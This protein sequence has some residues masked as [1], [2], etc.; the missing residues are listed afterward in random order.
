MRFFTYTW[1]LVFL[2]CALHAQPVKVFHENIHQGYQV[3]ASNQALYPVTVV[4]DIKAQNMIFSGGTNRQFLVP[5]GATRLDLGSFT[6][7]KPGKYGLN[8]AYKWTLGDASI[9]QADPQIVYDLPFASGQPFR[10]FQGYFGSYSHQK[11]YALDFTMPEGTPILA[12][13]EG[14]CVEVV[15]N[16]NQGC[17]NRSCESYNN[18]ITIMH[19]DGSFA[20]Y[21]H[22]KY[23]GSAIK[24]GDQVKRGTVIG[25]SGNT[26]YSSGPHLHFICFLGSLDGIRSFPTVFKIGSGNEQAQLQEG[27]T[28]VRNY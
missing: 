27:Q 16:H 22:L 3:F 10:L 7:D 21:V 20:R 17:P 18:F 14:T 23:Q 9:S 8:Y 26:G 11:E 4:L 13:R 28:Y 6:V 25:Y 2:C 5:P 12:A 15:V 24:P 19:S 1:L